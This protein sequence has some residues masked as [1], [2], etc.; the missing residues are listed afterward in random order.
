MDRHGSET[1]YIVGE[2][3]VGEAGGG[4]NAALRAAPV[5]AGPPAPPFHFSRLGPSGAGK[6]LGKPNRLKI[7]LAMTVDDAGQ[8]TIPAGFTYLGQFIDHDLT[9]DKSDLMEGAN[10]SPA[11]LLQSR[12]PSLDLDSLYGDGPS[13]P[14]SAQL[15]EADGL[16]LKMGAAVGGPPGSDLPRKTGGTAPGEAIIGDPRNDENLAVAQTHCAFIRFHTRVIDTLGAVPLPQRFHKA[17][18]IVTKHYQWLIRT[19]YLPRI[20]QPAV[21]TNVFTQGRKV[22]EVGGAADASADDAGR[23]LRRRVPAR[24]QHGSRHV[25]LE[26]G[27]PGRHAGAALRLHAQERRPH[28]PDPERLDRRLPAALQLRPAHA[29]TAGA[30]RPGGRAEQGDAD[31][32][33][34]RQPAGDAPRAGPAAREEPRLPE[35]APREHG[36]AGDG[37]ADGDVPEE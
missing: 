28:R 1:Y 24:A 19:D 9:F 5:T 35:P 13:D 10:I 8:G 3:I 16:H 34:A 21:V 6:Q 29:D 30:D 31:R 7:A 27:V 20:C 37:P 22:F 4:R 32:H 2:G 17:R 11:T 23:V 12:S 14:A 36:Q 26:R 33:E 18:E 25:Q 15:Y